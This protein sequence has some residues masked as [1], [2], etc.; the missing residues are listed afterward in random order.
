LE[1][2]LKLL[3][4]PVAEPVFTEHMILIMAR[5]PSYSLLVFIVYWS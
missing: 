5:A 2:F 3:S 1:S 4:N